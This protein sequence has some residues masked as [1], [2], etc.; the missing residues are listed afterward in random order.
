MSVWLLLIFMGGASW[1][2]LRYLERRKSPRKA[3]EIPLIHKSPPILPIVFIDYNDYHL[4]SKERIAAI[5]MLGLPAFMIGYIFYQNVILAAALASM[6]FLFPRFRRQQLI[7]KRK[8]MLYVQFKQALSCLSSSM[9]VGKSIESAFREAWEDLKLLYPDPACLIVVEFGLICRKVEN[10]EPIEAALK[11]FAD[12]SHLEDILSFSDVFLTC[13]RTG[14]NLVEV[15]KRTATVIA[16][17]LDITQEIS[18]MVAQKRFES[19]V[20][21][22]A[23]VLIVAVLAF[24]SPDYMVPLYRGSGILIMT[25]CLSLLGAC[26]VLTQK[27]MN[28]KV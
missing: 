17:K 22:V 15:M 20:L 14:G 1:L 19:R 24:S 2:L 23:P 27:I 13:K 28:I 8:N 16:E 6:G 9:T 18:V 3:S 5:L 26:Y 10:G 7:Q 4:S 21:V 11:H 12:R 25:V